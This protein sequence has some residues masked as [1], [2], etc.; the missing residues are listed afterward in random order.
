MKDK[1]DNEKY[2]PQA[3]PIVKEYGEAT[4]DNDIKGAV[5]V[6]DYPADADK[7]PEI[8]VDVP[9]QL[10]D[11]N[12]PGEYEVDVTITYPDGSIDT[13]PWNK[14]V[15]HRDDE[16]AAEND[17]PAEEAADKDSKGTEETEE[18][19]STA[20]SSSGQLPETGEV[21]ATAIFGAAAL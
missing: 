11:G 16:G 5:T 15:F 10:P 18:T 4:T 17:K 3:K 19:S 12:T 1:S 7:Q 13:I 6:P 2:E 8:K 21:D 20:K 9:T 14:L